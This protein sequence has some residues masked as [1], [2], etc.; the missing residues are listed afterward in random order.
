MRKTILIFAVLLFFIYGIFGIPKGIRLSDWQ[1]ALA[2]RIH[3]GLDLKGGIHL[4]LQVMV[5][6]AVSAETDNAVGRIQAD[7]Q[8]GGFP[9]RVSKPDPKQP[10]QIQILGTPAD[11]V[12]DVRSLLDSRY[13]TQYTVS[14]G[15]NN[16]WNLAMKQTE[17][18]SIEQ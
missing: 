11:K 8:Q 4:V 10:Q 17:V 16:S 6:E 14:S 5:D 12:S 18:Q 13:G 9:A 7:L 2:D 1:A 15:P 3:L